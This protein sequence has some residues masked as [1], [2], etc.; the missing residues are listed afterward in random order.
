[1]SKLPRPQGHLA[2]LSSQASIRIRLRKSDPAGL[3][4]APKLLFQSVSATSY[5]KEPIMLWLGRAFLDADYC[6]PLQQC[7]YSCIIV[8]VFVMMHPKRVA[9]GSFGDWNFPSKL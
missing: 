8:A 3:E 1:M 4:P 2:N 5:S 9:V 6:H 7:L